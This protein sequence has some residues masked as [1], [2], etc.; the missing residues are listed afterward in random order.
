LDVVDVNNTVL[1]IIGWDCVFCFFHFPTLF[2]TK[3]EV[4]TSTCEHIDHYLHE[5]HFFFD[6]D[7]FEGVVG[8]GGLA[9]SSVAAIAVVVVVVV[10]TMLV[11]ARVLDS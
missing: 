6:L 9:D 5:R 1:K 8:C 4:V 10:V 2:N 11:A 7:L 3:A